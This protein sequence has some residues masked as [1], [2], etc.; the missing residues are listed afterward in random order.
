MTEIRHSRRRG[1][2]VVYAVSYCP[3]S[4]GAMKSIQEAMRV[5]SGIEFSLSVI[6]RALGL[7]TAQGIPTTDS[8]VLLSFCRYCASKGRKRNL[9][10]AARG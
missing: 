10:R 6:A 2:R 5:S 4:F 9:G 8:E 1:G 7:M 3:Q